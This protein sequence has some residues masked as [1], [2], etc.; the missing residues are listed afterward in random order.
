MLKLKE[1]NKNK[2]DANEDTINITREKESIKI[3]KKD[4]KRRCYKKK[5]TQKGYT[6]LI[7]KIREK[8]E[9]QM[10]KKHR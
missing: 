2:K 5:K 3:V 9:K 4:E 7:P 10:L 6:H 1:E 8:Y